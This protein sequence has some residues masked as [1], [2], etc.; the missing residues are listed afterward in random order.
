MMLS[1]RQRIAEFSELEI[2]SSVTVL[3]NGLTINDRRLAPEARCRAGDRGI[4]VAP[5]VSIAGKY[6]RPAMLN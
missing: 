3:H 2:R 1:G 5:I 4:A 6:M